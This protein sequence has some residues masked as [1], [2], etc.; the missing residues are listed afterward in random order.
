MNDETG[1]KVR[2]AKPTEDTETP[3]SGNSSLFPAYLIS[4]RINKLCSFQEGVE[5]TF[6]MAPFVREHPSLPVPPD[7][8]LGE[9]GGPLQSSV[10]INFY[11]VILEDKYSQQKPPLCAEPS[12]SLMCFKFVSV[13]YGG[14]QPLMQMRNGSCKPALQGEKTSGA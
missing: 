13:F 10:P 4:R 5:K 8:S 12:W 7:F 1:C 11:Y 2:E 9:I 6:A 3:R 14:L